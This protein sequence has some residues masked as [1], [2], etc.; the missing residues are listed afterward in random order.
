MTKFEAIGMMKAGQKVR[1]RYFSP[2]E[3]VTIENGEYVFEDG[4]RCSPNFF[5]M[6]RQQEF[7]NDGWE[8]FNG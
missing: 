6:D 1:H 4:V 7:W 8:I 3:W 2:D 5:W